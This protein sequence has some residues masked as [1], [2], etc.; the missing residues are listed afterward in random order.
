VGICLFP[1]RFWR[2]FLVLSAIFRS[3][4]LNRF[5]IKV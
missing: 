2:V 5:V 3:V 4:F 1:S